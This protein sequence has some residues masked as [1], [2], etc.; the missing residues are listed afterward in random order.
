MASL[1]A[2]LLNINKASLYFLQA[3]TFCLNSPTLRR[4]LYDHLFVRVNDDELYYDLPDDEWREYAVLGLGQFTR[5]GW[6]A[7]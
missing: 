6:V 5:K 7:S 4:I 3:P 2:R 1:L